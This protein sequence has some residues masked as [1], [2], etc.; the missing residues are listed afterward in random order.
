MSRPENRTQLLDY[1]G[2]VQ[3][4]HVWSWCAVNEDEKRV[5]LSIWTDSR[6]Q[7]EGPRTYAIQEPDWGLSEKGKPSAARNDHDQ[8]IAL[9]LDHGYEP[10]GYFIEA[11]DGR[12][13]PREIASTATSFVVRL[14]IWRRPDGIVAGKVLNRVE[15]R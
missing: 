10:W 7:D 8:K 3:L 14:E 4:N 6:L 5:Y 11:K 9:V 15:I 1:L 12:A 13:Q 2:A